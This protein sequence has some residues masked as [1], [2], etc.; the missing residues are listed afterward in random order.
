MIDATPMSYEEEDEWKW[1]EASNERRRVTTSAGT[2][3]TNASHH[4]AC[5][6]KYAE[7]VENRDNQIT[8]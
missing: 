8:T 2:P 1:L 5:H 3:M 7:A 4:F 6:D